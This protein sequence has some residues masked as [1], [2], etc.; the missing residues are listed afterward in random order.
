[1][2]ITSTLKL[3]NPKAM[4]TFRII[5]TG[6]I[7]ILFMNACKQSNPSATPEQETSKILELDA[8]QVK[9]SGILVSMPTIDTFYESFPVTAMLISPPEGKSFLVSP[10]TGWVDAIFAR[11]G[12]R[13]SKG[14]PIL[15]IRSTDVI[16]WLRDYKELRAE[17]KQARS[18]YERLKSLADS[19]ITAR[20]ELLQAETRLT[21][22]QARFS[23]V[24]A[25]LAFLDLDTSSMSTTSTFNI[26]APISGILS[27]LN[28]NINSS[29]SPGV[30]LGYIINSHTIQL[31]IHL[32]PKDLAKINVGQQV[33]FT[34]PD[35]EN[36]KFRAQ[37]YS[38]SPSID[39]ESG[40][41]SALAKINSN[42]LPYLAENLTLSALVLINPR[43]L[44]SIPETAIIESNNKSFVYEVISTENGNLKL[45]PRE[46]HIA[47][48][49]GNRIAITDTL[50]SIVTT[51]TSQLPIP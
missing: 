36:K 33:E 42:N 38:I 4:K 25:R 34:L 12:E 10:V 18:D 14:T 2:L 39:P 15:R 3:N 31:A 26:R 13:I 43:I 48:K 27:N 47:T 46:L 40:G 50:S 8:D 44:P 49:S 45:R 30:Q 22:L 16:E 6:L 32:L 35:L 5:Y 17:L 1:M 41:L 23:A 21:T 37:V 19:E 11:T 20:K 24:S 9:E 29:I 51:G 7:L 28:I